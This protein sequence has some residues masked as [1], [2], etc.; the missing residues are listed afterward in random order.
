VLEEKLDLCLVNIKDWEM[1]LNF[2][3]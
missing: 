2:D 3:G 1:N